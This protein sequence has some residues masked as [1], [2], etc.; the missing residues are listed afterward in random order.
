MKCYKKLHCDDM[1]KISD[2]IYN[3][4]SV[5]TTILQDCQPGWHF[6]D[7][8]KLLSTVP[9]LQEYFHSLKLIPRHSAVTMV[10]D[11]NSLP[12]HSDEPPVIAKINMPVLNTKGWSN[13]WFDGDQLI[14]E[15]VDQAQPIVF[16]SQIP[17][18][19][20]QSGEVKIPRIVASFTFHNE[21]VELLK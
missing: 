13:R 4:L 17:H 1:G 15:L 6:V 3:F 10:L 16:N 14:D 20:V 18:S 9:E 5:N 12:V 19:V 2:G 8:K 21:P 11:N 7:L